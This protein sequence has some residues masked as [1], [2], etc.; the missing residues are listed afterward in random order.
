MI[1]RKHQGATGFQERRRST[2]GHPSTP[3]TPIHPIHP[4]STPIHPIH[5][6]QSGAD[7][8]VLVQTNTRGRRLSGTRFNRTA[9]S[10][11]LHRFC[12]DLNREFFWQDRALCCLLN[13]ISLASLELS[14]GFHKSFLVTVI[15]ENTFFSLWTPLFAFWSICKFPS[16][17]YEKGK[18]LQR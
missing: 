14:N 13:S 5:H 6:Q 3:S 16:C 12:F 8:Y 2:I 7:R 10:S 18:T 15:T 9:L 17:K 4:P 11:Y 1:C